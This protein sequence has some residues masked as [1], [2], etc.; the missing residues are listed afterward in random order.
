MQRNIRARL[1]L[2]QLHTRLKTANKIEPEHAWVCEKRLRHLYL[3]MKNQRDPKIRRAAD[4]DAKELGRRDTDDSKR[5]SVQHHLLVQDL[6][7]AFP[8]LLPIAV[9][10][11]C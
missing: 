9:A 2:L 8:L 6:G 4:A 11:H 7:I 1:R 5:R 3:R 10:H